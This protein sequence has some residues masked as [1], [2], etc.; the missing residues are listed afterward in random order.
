MESKHGELGVHLDRGML[1]I[2]PVWNRNLYSADFVFR[3]LVVT[4]NRTSMESKLPSI[5][6]RDWA[7]ANCL[8]IE[9]VWN[10]NFDKRNRAI[11]K[12]PVLLI[13][14]VWNRNNPDAC[15]RERP[16]GL[17]IEPVW[18]RNVFFVFTTGIL[19]NF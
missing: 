10:R 4:S 12:C 19:V 17:L 18:N 11:A 8:L 14:P 16:H 15:Y 1:L 9:P 7:I 3:C 5:I 2:E 6:Q 13:E